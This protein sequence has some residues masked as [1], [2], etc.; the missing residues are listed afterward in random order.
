[1]S[2]GVMFSQRDSL[3]SDPMYSNLQR[4]Y[5]KNGFGEERPKD[6]RVTVDLNSTFR[7]SS[8]NVL[9]IQILDDDD[10][11]FY[12][13]LNL[14]ENDY[15][16]L[17]SSQ[18]LLVD[19]C[20]FPTHVV[21][22]LEQCKEHEGGSAKFLLILEEEGRGECG[23]TFIRIVETNNFKHLCHLVL[24]INHGS[25]EDVKKIMVSPIYIENLLFPRKTSVRVLFCQILDV[26]LMRQLLRH[27]KRYSEFRESTLEISSP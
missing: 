23:K 10:P 20:S 17:K 13:S 3:Q 12:Y 27:L 18:G 21:R 7:Q 25:D 2:S 24:Q 9:Q 4:F 15:L 19:F 8:Q 11:F 5:V 22:L 26:R 6:L 16:R 1:M 14:T